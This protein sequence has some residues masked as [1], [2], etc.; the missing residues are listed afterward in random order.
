MKK[1]GL[2]L[3][4]FSLCLVFFFTV[5]TQA[6]VIKLT[7]AEQNSDMSWGVTRAEKP[8][9][10]KIEEATKGRVKIDTFYSQTLVKGPDVW[11]AVKNGV[12][13]M[14]WCMHGYWPDM[15]PLTD[16]MTLP[17]LPIKSAEKASEVLW[18]LYEKFPAIQREYKDVHVLNTIVADPRFLITTKK[19]IK[20]MDDVKGMK[21][22]ILGGPPTDQMKALGAVPLLM[23]MP[24]AYLSLD[25]GVIDGMDISWEGVLSFRLYEV[26]KYYTIA[27]LTTSYNT[28]IMNKQ[29]WDSL[30]KDIQAAISSVCGLEG[31]RFWGKNWYDSVPEAVAEQIKKENRTMIKYS[32]PPDEVE[33]WTKISA[34]PIWKAWVKKMEGKGVPEAQQILNTTI[35]LLKQ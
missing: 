4:L 25:K 24:D 11:N 29:K 5:P 31:S 34:E 3:W 14:G 8:W 32:L 15:T 22:R 7:L 17:A 10:K 35:E 20:T 1:R 13:D 28:V 26:V 18:K 30:P 27:P 2:L 9:I 33:K 23:P 19:Q 21:L 16:V 6:Q 12:A